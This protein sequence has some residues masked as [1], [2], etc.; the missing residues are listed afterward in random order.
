MVETQYSEATGSLPV[1]LNWILE[2]DLNQNI[3]LTSSGS[4][5][6]YSTSDWMSA[7]DCRETVSGF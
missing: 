1:S 3:C 2:L 7:M 4:L 6:Y 5:I